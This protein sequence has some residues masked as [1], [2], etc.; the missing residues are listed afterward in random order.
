[1]SSS[2]VEPITFAD[3]DQRH[4]GCRTLAR[5]D[6]LH[7]LVAGPNP[8]LPGKIAAKRLRPAH[9]GPRDQTRQHAV[10]PRVNPEWQRLELLLGRGGDE[11][12]RHDGW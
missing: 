5:N 1:M 6:E 2:V 4:H 12:T 7:P 10:H 3:L 9:A 8:E 11:D